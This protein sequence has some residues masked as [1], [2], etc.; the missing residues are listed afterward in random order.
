MPVSVFFFQN[1]AIFLPLRQLYIKFFSKRQDIFSQP[2]EGASKRDAKL[3][4][5]G[6][7]F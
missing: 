2:K 5:K 7:I 3:A 4:K 1:K 6:H